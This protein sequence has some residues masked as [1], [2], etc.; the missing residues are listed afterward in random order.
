MRQNGRQTVV[1]SLTFDPLNANLTQWRASRAEHVERFGGDGVIYA[2]KLKTKPQK[3]KFMLLAV[4]LIC[5]IVVVLVFIGYRRVSTAPQLILSTVTDQA[6][7]SL[8]KIH[9]TATRDGRTEWILDA[10]SAQFIQ[11]EN[12]LILANLSMTFFLKDQREIHLTAEKGALNTES[13]DMQVSGNVVVQT[14][15]YRLNTKLLNYIHSQNRIHTEVPVQVSGKVGQ[16]QAD[17]MNLE[18]DTNVVAF[19][20]NVEAIYIEDLAL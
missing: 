11:A 6:D 18:L 10:A 4:I 14:D 5:M 7:V 15:D 20:G 2:M 1:R 9:Q 12:K 3:L 8:G 16:L 19:K 17:S 13:K